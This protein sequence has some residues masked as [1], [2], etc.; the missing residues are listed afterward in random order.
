MFIRKKL[1]YPPYCFITLIKISSKDFNYGIG[2]AKKISEFLKRSLSNTTT[3]LG[4][5]IANILR[6]NNNYNFQVILKYKKD[7]KLYNALNE[8]LKIYEGNSKIK[9][10]FDFNPINL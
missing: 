2:E 5:S 9:V 4:P 6:I 3:V 1:N 10:E 7:D 8:L